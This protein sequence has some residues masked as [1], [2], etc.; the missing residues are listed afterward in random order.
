MLDIRLEVNTDDSGT[1][2]IQ[3]TGPNGRTGRQLRRDQL[4][5]LGWRM[6]GAAQAGARDFRE[7]RN[8]SLGPL[9]SPA[10]FPPAEH[11]S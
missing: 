5:R 9:M 10:E 6:I 1:I 7:E 11:L 4:A 3:R 8:S 2:Q